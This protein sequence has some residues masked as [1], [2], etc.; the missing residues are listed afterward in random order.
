M[1][2]ETGP[3]VSFCSICLQRHPV[4]WQKTKSRLVCRRIVNFTVEGG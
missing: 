3:Q 1:G 4:L 2:M